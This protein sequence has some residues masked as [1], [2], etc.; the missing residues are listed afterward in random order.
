MAI[1]WGSYSN[2]LKLGTEVSISP[3]NPTSATTSVTVTIKWYV[4][5]DGWD[6]EDNQTLTYA[7]D[8]SGTTTFFNNLN[9]SH[10]THQGAVQGYLLVATRVKVVSLVYGSTQSKSYKATLSGSIFGDTPTRTVSVTIPARPYETPAAPSG[11]NVARVSDTQQTV[12]WT[13]NNTSSAPYT[14]QTVQRNVFSNGSWSGFTNYAN[15]GAT[16]TS[17]TDTGTVADRAY[18]YRLTATN[19]SG[20]SGASAAAGTVYTTPA[21]P[22]T[23][24][25]TKTGS[26]DIEINFSKN[27][28]VSSVEHVIEHSADGGAF[29]VLATITT[30]QIPYTHVSPNTSQT[31]TYRVKNRIDNASAEAGDNLE[32]AYSSNSNTV[33]LTAPPNAPTNLSTDKSIFDEDLDQSVQ[34]WVH[35]PVDSSAQRKRQIRVRRLGDVTW[36]EEATATIAV[37]SITRLPG[38]FSNIAGAGLVNGETVEWQVRTW[39]AATTG[40]ADGTGASAWS[41][42]HTLTLRDRPTAAIS[43]P[44]PSQVLTGS[45]VTVAWTYFQAQS[46]AQAAYSVQLKIGSN[47]VATKTGSGTATSV[48]FTGL[49]NLTSYTASV[50]VT[51]ADGLVST[52]DTEAFSTSFL[53]PVAVDAT[54][55]YFPDSASVA[56]NLTPQAVVGGVTVDADHVTIERAI[57]DGPW[58][59][60]GENIPPD[61]SVVDVKPTINGIN[62]YRLTVYSATPSAIVLDRVHVADTPSFDPDNP[63]LGAA[64]PVA[65]GSCEYTAIQFV[66]DN[67]GGS[68]SLY[69]DGW[70]QVAACEEN[71]SFLTTGPAFTETVAILCE[72]RISTSTSRNKALQSFAGRLWPLEMSTDALSQ[73]VTVSTSISGEDDIYSMK[74]LEALALTEDI[75]LWRDPTGR[76]MFGSLGAVNAGQAGLFVPHAWN[77]GFTIRR[78]DYDG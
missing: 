76:R 74:A 30:A 63:P 53:P 4:G 49:S 39:G 25:A 54:A 38:D 51:S 37:S 34:T 19:T 43:S 36:V 73:S 21:K 47:V 66:E 33:Q 35:N 56:I 20:T 15:V 18:D 8:D 70:V 6:Y 60:I 14:G 3:S 45:S 46:S 26:G 44:T 23:P 48:E 67:G 32:S 75:V 27:C 59:T 61:S 40:G 69:E 29:S 7:N 65:E 42:T 31:H 68:Y 52:A 62:R 11:V 78:V 17:Y 16:A 24:V 64:L 2:H 22:S 13:R 50:V 28:T 77:P 5:F 41:A 10:A 55:V 72:A 57:N 1:S 9:G 71:T 12:T 58:V